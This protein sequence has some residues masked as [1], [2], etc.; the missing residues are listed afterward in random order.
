MYKQLD[1]HELD[2]QIQYRLI[3]RLSRSESR[4][5][6]LVEN[7]QEVVFQL[8]EQ[9]NFLF[10]NKTWSS[11]TGIPVEKALRQPVSNF[12]CASFQ[13]LWKDFVLDITDNHLQNA[14]LD[15]LCLAHADGGARWVTFVM[16]RHKTEG[17]W[18]GSMH[19]ITGD[20]D[21][22]LLRRQHRQLEIIQNA[23][24]RF[25]ENGSPSH[26]FKKL[27]PDILK[28]TDS[29]FGFI[30]EVIQSGPDRSLVVYA[31][32]NI[33]WDEDDHDKHDQNVSSGLTLSSSDILFGDVIRN[34]EWVSNNSLENIATIEGGFFGFAPLQSYLGAPIHYGKRLIGVIGLA[35][36]P[37]GYDE[38]VIKHLGPI[39]S[40]SAQLLAAAGRERERQES[41]RLLEQAIDYAKRAN[42]HKSVFLANMSHE[43][44]TPMNA[45]I[46]MSELALATDLD[47]RQRNYIGKIRSAS[48]SLLRIINDI[49]DFSKIE[50]GKLSLEGIPFALESVFD[51][52]T[53]LFAMSAYRQGVELVYD[54]DGDNR[55]LIGDPLRLGQVLTNLVSNAL[56]FSTKGNIVV[57]V[58]PVEAGGET[59]ELQFSVI[60][61][62]VGMTPEQTANLFRPF[63]QADSSTTRKYGGTGLGLAISRQLIEMMEGRIWVESTP[64][65]GSAFHCTARFPAA[66]RVRRPVEAELAAKLAAHAGGR[67]LIVDN[68]PAIRKVLAKLIGRLGLNVD[69]ARDAEEA[70]AHIDAA[71]DYL[72]CIVDWR[73][74]EIDGRK[75]VRRLR[76]AYAVQQKGP[77]PMLLAT[78][79]TD[80]R[81][82]T[83]GEEVD[84]LLAKPLSAAHIYA[85]IA[86]SLGIELQPISALAARKSEAQ[87]QWS[88][89]SALDI[90]IVEDVDVSREVMHGLLTNAGL[91]VRFANNGVEALKS[92]QQKRPGLILMDCH[93]PGMD[94][95][96]ATRRLRMEHD[97][98]DLPIIA[99]TANATLADQER[100]LEA[101][102]NAH[103]AKPIRM[104]VLYE[105]MTRCFPDASSLPAPSAAAEL[106][107]AEQSELPRFPGLDMDVA[108][109]YVGS[110][111]L[112][113][114][115]LKKFRDKSGKNFEA[116]FLS[117]VADED[118]ET[119]VRLAHSL[120]GVA[121]TLGAATLAEAAHALELAANEKNKAQCATLL[122]PTVS[123]LKTIVAGLSGL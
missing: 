77:P 74:P 96:E 78:A 75:T 15:E 39:A 92:V 105:R 49:L 45:I 42:E 53:S 12:I 58:R 107:G 118:W 1:K 68:N 4:Y 99:L 112:L 89:F 69:S 88:R 116:N 67:A 117:A 93:M 44:R 16:Q 21:A 108:L 104:D 31:V 62:G 25:I 83:V 111:S 32:D 28:L 7:V 86:R 109:S 110:P 48:E 17:D 63:S 64:G 87:P 59:V 34:G 8:D 55:L 113:L 14:R 60:D 119:Q 73:M 26:L 50:A 80:I 6:S 65:A 114:R 5:Q 97:A 43:I 90:L 66:G 106:G 30:G 10:L 101:G 41:A 37:G 56:K 61:E 71:P 29:E 11:L 35:N 120:K 123:H 121:K 76:A 51:Q 24:A 115:V 47:D 100:C 38:A 85:G 46:G 72:F 84:G 9:F 94:G 33:R 40:T 23:Q 54:I 82:A 102:M 3:E 36:R 81:Q 95:Y 98:K 22:E 122:P 20:R 70:A 52:L 103:V 27:L 91:T 18:I 19:N 79:N 57:R 13:S 2:L